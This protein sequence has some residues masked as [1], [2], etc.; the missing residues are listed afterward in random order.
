LRTLVVAAMMEVELCCSNIYFVTAC[1][2]LRVELYASRDTRSTN[3]HGKRISGFPNFV[4]MFPLSSMTSLHFVYK[5][6]SDFL[7]Q[8]IVL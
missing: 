1:K 5:E 7:L 4:Y 8:Q 3:N 6:I 2:L